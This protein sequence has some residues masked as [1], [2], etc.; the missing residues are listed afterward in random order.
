MPD[1]IPDR[2]RLTDLL[3]QQWEAIAALVADLDENAWRAPSPLPGWTIHD[4]VAHVVGTESWLLGEKPPPHDPLRP[5]TDL[6]SLPH[7]RNEVAMLNEIW[8][9]RLR[10]LSGA[11]LLALYDEVTERRRAVLASMDDQA[12][13]EPTV[14]P[15]G[16]VPYARFMR[17]RLFDCWMHQLDLADGLGRSVDEGGARAEAAFDELTAGL[18]RA[19]VKGAGTPDDTVVGFELTGP[20]RREVWV[21][22]RE[23]RGALIDL[24]DAEPAAVVTLDS[25]LFARL[26]GGRTTVDAHPGAYALSGDTALGERLI[27]S[28]A[29]TI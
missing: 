24:V 20:L 14:S 22:V 16:Q 19:V 12:W 8:V 26:R 6:R 11:R 25:G 29:F 9:D 23:G 2:E 17:V 7:V 10:P 5:K 3:A 28:L 13:S 21:G 15:I 4:V 27:R 1:R 18:G